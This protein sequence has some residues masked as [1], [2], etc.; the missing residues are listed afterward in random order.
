MPLL[1]CND[2][3]VSENGYS[4]ITVVIEELLFP[5]SSFPSFCKYILKRSL[6]NEPRQLG[7]FS[8][9]Q[10]S[11]PFLLNAGTMCTVTCREKYCLFD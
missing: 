6:P 5:S 4:K 8:V 1:I 3:P 10:A 2:P 7:Y 9:A 11:A